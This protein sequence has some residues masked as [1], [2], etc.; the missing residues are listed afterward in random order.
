MMSIFFWC[1]WVVVR[2]GWE[3]GFYAVLLG[4]SCCVG[5]Y[6][7]CLVPVGMHVGSGCRNLV[8]YT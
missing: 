3:F 1:G 6:V 7:L 8:C 5:C 2:F 4:R